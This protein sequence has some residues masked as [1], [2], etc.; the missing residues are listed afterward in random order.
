[1]FSVL[2]LSWIYLHFSV[3]RL[4]SFFLNALPRQQNYKN[5]L[6][7]LAQRSQGNEIMLQEVQSPY[8]LNFSGWCAPWKQIVHSQQGT[9]RT[10]PKQVEIW[11]EII[12]GKNVLSLL[13]K[14]KVTFHRAWSSFMITDAQLSKIS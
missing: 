7:E 9:D 2:F 14:D 1:M 8:H 4:F 3:W 10:S 12:W 5:D 11:T 13:S 6:W